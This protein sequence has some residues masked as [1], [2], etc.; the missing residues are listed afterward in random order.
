L[1]HSQASLQ[2]KASIL[3]KLE[4]MSNLPYIPTWVPAMYSKE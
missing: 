4:K 1:E 2:L 3:A